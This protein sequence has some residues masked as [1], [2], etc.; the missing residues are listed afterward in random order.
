MANNEDREALMD[1]LDKAYPYTVRQGGL[2]PAA[3]AILAAGFRRPPV[4]GDNALSDEVL[5][6][7]YLDAAVIEHQRLK[8]SALNLDS[9]MR[10]IDRAGLRAVA[11]LAASQP[12]EAAPSDTTRCA[13]CG[14]SGS[15]VQTD[16]VTG[17]PVRHAHHHP[18]QV[19][20]APSD[21]DREA[22]IEEAERVYDGAVL[23]DDVDY[24]VGL[25][26]RLGLAL[27]RSSHPVQVEAAPS[28]TTR[29]ATCGWSGS[30]VQTDTVT[31]LPVRHAHH[32]PVQVE[33]TNDEWGVYSEREGNFY[34]VQPPT[35]ENAAHEA[36]LVGEAH[37]PVLKTL[38]A[39]LSNAWNHGRRAALGGG[40]HA[41]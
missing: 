26:Q 19:E 8:I 25:I 38:G 24:E 27:A 37:R 33:V 15:E 13:T 35:Y 9:R 31:G 11:N 4:S 28:D 21:T 7:T 23:H 12:R 36:E 41:E 10:E 1:A 18:V 32:H 29:C 5:R 34:R 39:E 6:Q 20:V 14:W 30:E 17:L 2:G 40:G 16:T 22:L 3:D